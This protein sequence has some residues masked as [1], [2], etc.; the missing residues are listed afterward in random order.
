LEAVVFFVVVEYFLVKLLDGHLG[1]GLQPTQTNAPS[2][3]ADY[4]ANKALLVM[5]SAFQ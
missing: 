1:K 3:L 5:K 2:T 4:P